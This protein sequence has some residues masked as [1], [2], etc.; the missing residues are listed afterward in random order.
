MVKMHWHWFKLLTECCAINRWCN[1]PCKNRGG[2]I[3]KLIL[4]PV[5]LWWD[6]TDSIWKWMVGAW[7][8]SLYMKNCFEHYKWH[9]I[10]RWENINS[11][12]SI[13]TLPLP[14]G[15]NSFILQQKGWSMCLLSVCLWEDK[16]NEQ[17]FHFQFKFYFSQIMSASQ[18][19][20]EQLWQIV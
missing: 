1:Q 20:G 19:L 3:C 14:P 9:W 13:F 5:N 2:A 10:H 16:F 7:V 4:S 8:N 12:C 15:G 6:P 11:L 17:S 18:V